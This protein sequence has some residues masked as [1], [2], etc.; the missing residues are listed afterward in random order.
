MMQ[1]NLEE[2]SYFFYLF[3]M[4]CVVVQVESNAEIVLA[5]SVDADN[6]APNEKVVQKLQ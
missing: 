3:Q 5:N 1:Y 4:F 2:C 6:E